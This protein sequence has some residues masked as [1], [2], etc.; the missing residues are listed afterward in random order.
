MKTINIIVSLVVFIISVILIVRM[1]NDAKCFVY[2][3]NF[4]ERETFRFGLLFIGL[5]GFWN[6]LHFENVPFSE[7]LVN[8]GIAIV[9]SGMMMK[10]NRR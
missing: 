8:I 10:K 1:F 5:G 2:R 7:V 3:W 6:C 9:F 4:L